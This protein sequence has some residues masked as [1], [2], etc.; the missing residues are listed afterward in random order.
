MEFSEE[1]CKYHLISKNAVDARVVQANEPVQARN[2]VVPHRRVLNNCASKVQAGRATRRTIRNTQFSREA[3]RN[4]HGGV[5]V[6]W[7]A[8]ASVFASC[9]SRSSSSFSVMRPVRRAG[10]LAFLAFALPAFVAASGFMKW[11]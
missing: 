4:V 2:L 11:V 6:S 9:S 5:E 3:L 7:M 8:G 10:E 1:E